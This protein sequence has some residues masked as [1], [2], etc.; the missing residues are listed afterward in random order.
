MVETH[1][2]STARHSTMRRVPRRAVR[3]IFFTLSAL[4]Y[5]EYQKYRNTSFLTRESLLS[6]QD[7][8]VS[9][10]SQAADTSVE[11]TGKMQRTDLNSVRIEGQYGLL[12]SKPE[13]TS[14]DLCK[15]D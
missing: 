1:R 13:P 12:W 8:G 14:G 10:R 6:R 5:V 3:I 2:C 7:T 11:N 15:G 9:E 4:T